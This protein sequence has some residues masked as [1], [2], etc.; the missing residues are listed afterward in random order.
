MQSRPLVLAAV[1]MALIVAVGMYGMTL[2]SF[3]LPLSSVAEGVLGIGSR[4]ADFI[5][6]TLRLPRVFTATVQ[7]HHAVMRINDPAA[8]LLHVANAIARADDAYKVTALDALGSDRLALLIHQPNGKVLR[9]E[10]VVP[11]VM[12]APDER[13]EQQALSEYIISLNA[14]GTYTGP[15][16]SVPDR[17]PPIAGVETDL[18]GRIWVRRGVPGEKSAPRPAFSS[19]PARAISMMRSSV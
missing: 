1:C 16:P 6:R 7:T 9:I 8:L 4:D 19:A 10:R 3:P 18:E 12:F 14:P 2:G 17:K 15:P 5:V 11:P 13:R